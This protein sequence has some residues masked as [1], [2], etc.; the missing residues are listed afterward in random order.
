VGKRA[1]LF[2]LAAA[3]ACGA[4]TELFGGEPSLDAGETRDAATFDAGA[5]D[6][7]LDTGT[8]DAAPDACSLNCTPGDVLAPRPI[9]PLSTARATSQRPRLRWELA[10][11]EDGAQ[12]EI[13]RDRACTMALVTFVASG[14]SGTPPAP[15]GKGVYYWRLRGRA[16]G[17][18]GTPV[19]PTWEL[20]IGARSAPIDSSFGT[21]L[22]VNEDGY[23]DALIAAFAT[24]AQGGVGSVYLYKGGPMA[25]PSTPTTI[26]SPLGLGG[27]FGTS[28]ASAGD[29][30][31]DGFADV[32]IGARGETGQPDGAA[33]VYLGGPN[34][35]STSYT[36][37]TSPDT[38]GFGMSVASA[39]DVN[40]DGYAD[41]V[42][43]AYWYGHAYVYLGGA[44]GISTSPITLVGSGN[45]FGISVAGAG[46]VNGDGYADILVGANRDGPGVAYLFLGSANGPSASPLAITSPVPMQTFSINFGYSVSGA[47]DVNGDGL[48]DVV[49]GSATFVNGGVA[50]VY[51][52]TA[53]G[54]ASTPASLVANGPTL[55]FGQSVAGAGDVNGDGYDD[56]VVANGVN[57]VPG[58]LF[59]YLGSANGITTTQAF[60]AN[61]G[62]GYA[63]V[64]AGA[65]DMNGDGFADF[66]SGAEYGSN[67]NGGIATVFFGAATVT[68]ALRYT[69]FARPMG[70]G[71]FGNAVARWSPRVRMKR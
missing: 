8:L 71:M 1:L 22:D 61:V 50:L 43:G 70:A 58:S 15:L 27:L 9:A 51:L 55:Y 57:Q 19:S 32:V 2:V 40:G 30:N 35:L 65:G 44:N 46:D 63:N 69:A 16:N 5:R 21:T 34:G 37:L 52:G 67:G 64:V 48:S 29:V 54:L 56:V 33:L 47:G 68:P 26:D 36:R 53:G 28:V 45:Q 12:V 4:R 14:T 18:T 42:V 60:F 17:L 3:T 20:F 62:G 31:G 6:A 49:I 24:G 38:T 39:G 23:A 41:V 11:G 25:P 7:A 10:N 59:L 13:C 66:L